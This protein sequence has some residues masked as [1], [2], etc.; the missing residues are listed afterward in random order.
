[1][2]S[3]ALHKLQQ[4]EAKILVIY[5]KATPVNGNACGKLRATTPCDIRC[6]TIRWGTRLARGCR[7]G[8]AQSQGAPPQ[9]AFDTAQKGT[10]LPPITRGQ[11]Y[12]KGLD[13][14]L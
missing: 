4:G 1:M 2:K 12:L 11:A 14:F 8:W 3:V 13:G 7:T 6:W 10:L 5:V 9:A